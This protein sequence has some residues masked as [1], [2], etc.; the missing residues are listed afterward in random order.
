[1]I[2][3]LLALFTS[4]N[5]IAVPITYEFSG[6]ITRMFEHDAETDTNTVV[7]NTSFFGFNVAVGDRFYGSFTYDSDAIESSYREDNQE[8]N[9]AVYPYGTLD[10]RFT[11]GDY[12][13]IDQTPA[14]TLDSLVVRNDSDSAHPDTFSV[15]SSN[16]LADYYTS[17]SMGFFD[18]DGDAFDGYEIPEDI[19]LADYLGYGYFHTSL[20]ERA[21]GDQLHFYG[22]ADEVALSVSEPGTMALLLLGIGLI[23]M[24]ATRANGTNETKGVAI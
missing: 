23:F 19:D 15:L 9:S 21:T 13:Y 4:M 20:L 14:S 16:P 24:R 7:T 3:G 11:L 17:A 22:H 1:M 10:F 12:T 5:S 2:A 8:R 18:R 6:S